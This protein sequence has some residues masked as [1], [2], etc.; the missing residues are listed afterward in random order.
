M[1]NLEIKDII[2]LNDNW[3]LDNVDVSEYI[4]NKDEFALYYYSKSGKKIISTLLVNVL[5]IIDNKY[6]ISNEHKHT[7]SSII[8]SKFSIKWKKLYDTLTYD[9][10]MGKPF[11]MNVEESTTNTLTSSEN[12]TFSK[13]VK[14]SGSESTTES[15][16]T[17]EN[18]LQGFNST[19]FVPSDKSVNTFTDT[20]ENTYN[21][22]VSENRTNEFSR[23]N[24]T[25]RTTNRV[26]NIGNIP[27][28]ELI[29]KERE[30]W[31]YQL[32]DVICSDLDTVL[33][34]RKYNLE[35]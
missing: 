28:Q 8:N 18:S 13:E 23:E 33:T 6:N 29:N 31:T 34:R 14:D 22:D 20:N 1:Y 26:G 32:W 9:Y 25:S 19:S 15:N 2:S 17:T 35:V 11:S 16:D 4:P 30:V 3:Y 5:N 12:S 27:I 24:P 10:D 7:I 21:S